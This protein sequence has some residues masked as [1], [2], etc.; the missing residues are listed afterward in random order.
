MPSTPPPDREAQRDAVADR[1]RRVATDR[2]VAA[3]TALFDY[4]APRINAYLLRIGTDATVAEEIAQETMVVL[5]QKAH[6]FDPTKSSLATWLFRV[7][8]N[9]RIDVLRRSRGMV[10]DEEATLAVAD[11]GDGPDQG[12][13]SSRRA[14]RVRAAMAELPRE[15]ATLIQLSFFD[16]RSHSEIAA[17][18]GLPLGTVKSRIRLA[19]G[20]LRRRLDMLRGD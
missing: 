1:V 6:L 14:D 13:D 10:L 17:A 5:W 8:R 15:Q 9:R 11:D 19:F 20:Q 7:A 2:D 3:F 18:T 16:E 4:Y 12:I